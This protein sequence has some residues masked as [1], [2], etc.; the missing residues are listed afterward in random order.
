MIS[1]AQILSFAFFH[2]YSKNQDD[3]TYNSKVICTFVVLPHNPRFQTETWIKAIVY[4]LFHYGC[5]KGWSIPRS[6]VQYPQT[7]VF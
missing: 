6:E 7:R 2:S 1:L 4:Y 3:M 5:S